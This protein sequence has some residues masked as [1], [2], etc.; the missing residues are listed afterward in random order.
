MVECYVPKYMY[1][2]YIDEI[3]K[4]GW[5]HNSDGRGYS[6]YY[7]NGVFAKIILDR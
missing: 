3:K 5:V 1:R 2:W 4:C 7:K 6:I